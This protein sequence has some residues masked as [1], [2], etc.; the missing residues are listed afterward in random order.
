[1]R[2]ND[3]CLWLVHELDYLGMA[4]QITLISKCPIITARSLLLLPPHA[5]HLEGLGLHR[6][7]RAG[8]GDVQVEQD[9]GREHAQ[10]QDTEH[11]VAVDVAVHNAEH[12]A[13]LPSLKLEK[14]IE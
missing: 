2:K 5:R 11:G 13:V 12:D 8:H 9:P 3:S 1:M 6:V 4:A 14:Y 7:T 10:H